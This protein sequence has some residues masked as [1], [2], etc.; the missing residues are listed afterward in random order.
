MVLN[1]VPHPN[2]AWH[3][4]FLSLTSMVTHLAIHE[5]V[6]HSQRE[7][8]TVSLYHSTVY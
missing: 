8:C 5:D 3:F 7:K 4:C 1:R 2:G 6:S